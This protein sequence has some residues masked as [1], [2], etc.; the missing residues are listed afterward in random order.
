[1][2]NYEE[3]IYDVNFIDQLKKKNLISSYD[4]YFD[5][6]KSDTGSI[7]IGSKPNEYMDGIENEKF[8]ED[9]YVTMKTSSSNGDLDWSVKFDQIY[10]GEKKMAHVKPM[11]LRIEFGIVTGYYEWEKV[12]E[13]EFFSKLITEKK[14]FKE[15]TND[16]GS[17]MH[18]FYCNK[19]TDLSG[20][21]L[22]FLQLMNLIIIS[23]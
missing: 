17:F 19:N 4:F 22:L 6:G 3:N 14:C 5:F 7:I 23:L 13:N 9:N 20:L 12:L 21:S 15:N 10:Y 16:L 11:V 1:M 18:F 8:N 2:K